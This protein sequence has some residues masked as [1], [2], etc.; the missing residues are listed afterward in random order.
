MINIIFYVDYT[1]P[2]F[3][4][5]AR[6]F[7]CCPT[8]NLLH[9]DIAIILQKRTV[10]QQTI[11]SV[12]R[13]SI[14]IPILTTCEDVW[15]PLIYFLNIRSLDIHINVFVNTIPRRDVTHVDYQ[16]TYRNMNLETEIKD[17]LSVIDMIHPLRDVRLRYFYGRQCLHVSGDIPNRFT[18][19]CFISNQSITGFDETMTVYTN[20]VGTYTLS[21]PQKMGEHTYSERYGASLDR[22]TKIITN[23]DTGL[24]LK[25]DRLH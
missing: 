23:G 20:G 22:I 6:S 25:L 7:D 8:R 10:L 17:M 2:M 13:V 21:R 5:I 12:R 1:V 14:D 16:L 24:L 3:N 9:A 4:E 15:G 18:L 19:S 11:D